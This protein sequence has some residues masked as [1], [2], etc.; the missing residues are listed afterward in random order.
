MMPD[1][2][3]FSHPLFSL[4]TFFGKEPIVLT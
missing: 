4:L 3:H 2:L 1:F